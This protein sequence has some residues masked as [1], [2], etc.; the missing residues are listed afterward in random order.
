MV[1][2][3]NVIIGCGHGALS[4]LKA[5]RAFDRDCDVVVVTREEHPPY[6]PT[7][8]PYI[9]ANKTDVSRFC[10]ADEAFFDKMGASF[11]MKKEVISIEPENK[12]IIYKDGDREDYNTLLIA[13][14][15]RP[16]FPSI[17]GLK[18]TGFF[19]LHTVGDCQRLLKH[20]QGGMDIAI[21]GAGLI[22]IEVAMALRQRGHR[23]KVIEREDRI[24]PLYFDR[25][26]AT[27]VDRVL[28][29]QGIET[30]TGKQAVEVK[31]DRGKRV[32]DLFDGSFIDTEILISAAGVEPS[33]SL[34]QGS[35]V[36]TNQ[37]VLVDNQMMTNIP[38]IY[39]AGDVAESPNFF[40]KE[41]GVS[42]I[43]PIAIAQGKVAGIHMAGGDGSE[44]QGWIPMNI[45]PFFGNVACSVGVCLNGGQ[46]LMEM[47]EERK[48][49]KKLIFQEERLVGAMFVNVTVDPGVILYLIE[50]RLDLGQYKEML[51]ERPREMSRWLMMETERKEGMSVQ[52]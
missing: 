33:I 20:L 27:L 32:I 8:L 4:A 34:L 18:E 14:G 37:G 41:P 46:V 22:G 43:I 50:K 39:A 12:E 44:Y 30:F 10:L 38:D 17:K 23:I 45:F 19:D 35:G 49:L 15:S 13:T 9:L 25:E 47:D 48:R 52:A 2:R 7:V 36:R 16:V 26:G 28:R 6:S 21:L 1:Q 40:T 42:A 31:R 29:D 24:L 3:K 5:I 51:F 11:I